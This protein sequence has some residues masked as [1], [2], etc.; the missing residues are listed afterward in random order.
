[1]SALLTF[2]EPLSARGSTK[3]REA[4]SLVLNGVNRNQP[5][6]VRQLLLPL[7]TQAIYSKCLTA[8]AL[9]SWEVDGDRQW[10][11]RFTFQRTRVKKPRIK[12]GIFAGIHGDEP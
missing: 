4:A 6:S 9:G 5:L 3:V 1:M 12:V 8:H 11:P 10:L 2:H 7:L